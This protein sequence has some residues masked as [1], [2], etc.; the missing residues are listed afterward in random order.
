MRLDQI[1]MHGEAEDR[2]V[3]AAIKLAWSYDMGNPTQEID[4]KS[5]DGSMSPSRVDAITSALDAKLAA[6]TEPDAEE[7]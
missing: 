6:P 2:D 7:K 1:I 4:H 5:T 3:I